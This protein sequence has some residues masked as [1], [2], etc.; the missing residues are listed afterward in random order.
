MHDDGIVHT[1]ERSDSHEAPGEIVVFEPGIQGEPVVESEASAR[2]DAHRE[3]APVE[4]SS[5]APPPSERLQARVG[6]G[7]GGNGLRYL[8]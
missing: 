7:A 2:A 1:C 5:G 4:L 6:Q 3:V 8:T